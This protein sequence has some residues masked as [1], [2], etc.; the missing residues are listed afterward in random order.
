MGERDVSK[1]CALLHLILAQGYNAYG[2]KACG[3]LCMTPLF[4]SV[5]ADNTVAQ[6]AEISTSTHIPKPFGNPS[7]AAHQMGKVPRGR[8]KPRLRRRLALDPTR[9]PKTVTFEQVDL[10][11]RD[12]DGFSRRSKIRF[13]DNSVTPQSLMFADIL[14]REPS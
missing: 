8:Y 4:E 2:L 13:L 3:F 1:K 7:S 6:H 11:D 12:I 9:Q 14:T 10:Y 5:L